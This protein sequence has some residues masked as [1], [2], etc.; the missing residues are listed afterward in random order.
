MFIT[1][2]FQVTTK[3]P[4]FQN[5]FPPC[6]ITDPDNIFELSFSLLFYYFVFIFSLIYLCIYLF[7]SL[8]YFI[9]LM[10]MLVY[11]YF[12]KFFLFMPD[13]AAPLGALKGTYK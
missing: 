12:L 6:F 10:L 4:S 7:I 1:A 8:F 3:N 9:L 5:S 2:L 13:C 11:F